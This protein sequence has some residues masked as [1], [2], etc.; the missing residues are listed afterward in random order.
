MTKSHAVEFVSSLSRNGRN[1][2]RV[3][4]AHEN[5]AAKLREALG[6]GEP[7][8]QAH[9]DRATDLARAGRTID[10]FRN[11]RQ[12]IASAV[13]TLFLVL[14]G[15]AHAKDT[16]EY[17]T[18]V[19]SSAERSSGWIDTTRCSGS[20]GY[21]QCDGGIQNTSEE[22]RV[23]TTVEGRGLS[24]TT[25]WDAQIPSRAL[26]TEPR[27]STAGSGDWA[28]T[29]YS[30]WCHGTRKKAGTTREGRK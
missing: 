15:L 28:W 18:G 25:R 23:L 22:V 21:V 3:I 6:M 30:S 7:G 24:S 13:V 5:G 29:S 4:L 20:T 19:I 16:K 1:S 11:W 26:Q 12:P 8:L 14:G 9:A 17:Q 27:F 10:L 2:S